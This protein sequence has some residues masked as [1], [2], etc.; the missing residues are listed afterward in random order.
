MTKK[1]K[2]TAE[3]INKAEKQGAKQNASEATKKVTQ[4]AQKQRPLTQQEQRFINAWC[5]LMSEADK[6]QFV[7]QLSND[8]ANLGKLLKQLLEKKKQSESRILRPH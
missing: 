7:L 6:A 2:P 1:D 8:V 3:A 5:A 4:N